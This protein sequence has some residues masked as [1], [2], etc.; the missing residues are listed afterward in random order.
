MTATPAARKSLGQNY[1]V[2]PHFRQKITNV[3]KPQAGKPIIEIGPGP[4]SLTEGLLA[5]GAHVIAVEMDE[6]FVPVLEELAAKYPQGKLTLRLGDALKTP[7]H[8]LAGEPAPLVGNLPYNV[9]TQIVV[10]ALDHGY[11]F[12][13][14][15]FLLQKEVVGRICA[16]AGDDDWGR[17]GVLCDLLAKRQKLFDVPAGAFRPMPK[18]TSSVVSLV[19]LSAPRLDVD[20]KKLE[21]ITRRAFGQR[22]KMLRASLKGL[23][24]EAD[25]S[26]TGIDPAARPET[27]TLESFAQLAAAVKK[28]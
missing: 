11:A 3:C 15:T 16:S 6:R 9:G 28:P 18:V 1:L 23:L 21:E 26:A 17:L 12:P 10:N 27:L 19:P 24:S 13:H 22:R 20:R 8:E 14:M 2:D 5:A 4:G 25:I 7:L